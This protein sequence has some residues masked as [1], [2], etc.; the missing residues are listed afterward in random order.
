MDEYI[1]LTGVEGS[2]VAEAPHILIV[3]DQAN[4]AE[5]LTS[6]FE[7][8]GYKVTSVGW[9]KDALT[10]TEKTIP[11][12]IMLDIRLPDIDGYEVCR[13]L[14]AHRRTEHVPIIF[15][16]ERRERGD[17]LMGLEL[18]AVDYITKPFDVQE[19]RLRVRNVL[20]RS[21]LEQLSHPITG[22]PAPSL[23]NERLHDLLTASNWAIL[24]VGLQGLKE[25]AESY[26][27]VA[28][29]D[30]VRAVALMLNHVVNEGPEPSA[31]VGHLDDTNLF[32]VVAADH[33]EEIR[34]ALKV[35]LSEAM[36]FFYPRSDWEAVQTNQDVELPRMDITIGVLQSS[37]RTFSSVEELKKAAIE[38]QM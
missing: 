36:S 12:L 4:T 24:S 23:S 10:F 18:G 11:D 25:F 32:V 38:A 2:D 19:L 5:M 27:F 26:G 7:A 8:Q 29:D 31:F 20:R 33:S 13:R 28:R 22:L 15:L 30:V 1:P 6:Y 34:Q 9:G 17:K 16:T 3:E 21:S 35:R 37:S 14:R